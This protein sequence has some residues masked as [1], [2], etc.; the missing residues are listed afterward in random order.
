MPDLTRTGER[1]LH[2][3]EVNFGLAADAGDPDEQHPGYVPAWHC[4]HARHTL[5][6][7]EC[8]LQ[9][10]LRD[11]GRLLAA[12]NGYPAGQPA[13]TVKDGLAWADTITGPQC[14]IP[15]P[16]RSSAHHT[17]ASTNTTCR[18]ERRNRS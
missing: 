14:W 9:W 13:R 17:H 16:A 8:S 11:R 1:A 18:P 4:G 10:E 6:W 2:R 15:R 12:L 5:R 7:S 3:L